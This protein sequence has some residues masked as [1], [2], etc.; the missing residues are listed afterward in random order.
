M[1]TVSHSQECSPL[2]KVR[3][4]VR[5]EKNTFEGYGTFT[6][7]KAEALKPKRSA[8]AWDVGKPER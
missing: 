1:N 8:G 7:D 6:Q 4:F 5:E 2:A 3:F